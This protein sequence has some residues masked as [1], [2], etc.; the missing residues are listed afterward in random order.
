MTPR[1]RI[2]AL[3][4][5][6]AGDDGVGLAVLEWLRARPVPAGVELVRAA[7]DVALVGLLETRAPVVLIDAVLGTPAGQVLALAPEE[8][9]A[10]PALAVSTH[11]M[12]IA[13]A[14]ELARVLA[15][16]GVSPSIRVVGVTIARPRRYEQRL[17][18]AVAA[19]VPRAG[20]RVL[21]LVGA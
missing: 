18:P 3:G 16:A 5:G 12:G 17:S 7:E 4:Q 6:A 20:E 11:G 14:I 9:A 13:T 15:P 19:A 1:A 8:L 21:A 10:G 2:I